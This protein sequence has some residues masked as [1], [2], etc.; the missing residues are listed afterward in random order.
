MA[1]KQSKHILFSGFRGGGKDEAPAPAAPPPY[2]PTK[3]PG[4]IEAT[5]LLD[6]LRPKM[7][8]AITKMT[9]EQIFASLPAVQQALINSQ[10]SPAGAAPSANWAAIN[11]LSRPAQQTSIAPVYAPVYQGGLFNGPSSIDPSTLSTP[12]QQFVYMA[13]LLGTPQGNQPKGSK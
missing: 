3:D 10:Q 13:G 9:P 7:D 11:N 2:D 5:K 6:S 1:T 12:A 8:A 4:Y